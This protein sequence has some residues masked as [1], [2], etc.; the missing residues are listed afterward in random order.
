MDRFLITGGLGFIGSAFVRRLIE[1]GV[2]PFVI[3]LETYAGDRRRLP[4]DGYEFERADVADSSVATSVREWNPDVVINFAAESHVTRS[5]SAADT[6]FR[7]N[8]AGTEN[9]LRACEGIDLRRFVH[10]STDEIYG[11]CLGDAYVEEDKLPGEGNATSAYARSKALADD[12]AMSFVDRIPLNVVR[13]TNCFGPWQH[14]EKAIAR[15]TTRA[16]RGLRMPVWGD[17]SQVRDWMHVE[18]FCRALFVVLESAPVGEVYNAGPQGAQRT[19][20]EVASTIARVAGLEPADHVY[21]TEY[22]RPQHDHRYAIDSSKLR[23]LGWNPPGEIDGALQSTFEW[24]RANREWW[25]P[26]LDDAE[27]L[28]S[29]D[30]ERLP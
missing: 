2:R 26:L 5:E 4:E 16:L 30:S 19:N 15:W 28:Y 24:Y 7:A 17:G 13:P 1:Q 27:G 8:V 6:F 20:L 14:P 29:D 11:P 22:D 9:V 3:D 10:I 23:K 12:I 18:D 21:L 25:E